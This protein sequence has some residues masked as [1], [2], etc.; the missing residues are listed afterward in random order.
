[1]PWI[2]AATA[3]LRPE[4]PA[5]AERGRGERQPSFC[6]WVAGIGPGT[7]VEIEVRGPVT[8]HTVTV[9]QLRRWTEGAVPSP[10]E[11]LRRERLRG[12]LGEAGAA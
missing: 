8:R 5:Q 10:A 12:I 6:G 1:M 2:E 3:L 11:R 9:A 7:R 4:H